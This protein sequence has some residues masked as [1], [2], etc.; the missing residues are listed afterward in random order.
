MKLI[1]RMK[2]HAIGSVMIVILVYL[3]GAFMGADINFVNWDPFGRFILVVLL[4]CCM[5]VGNLGIHELIDN[6]EE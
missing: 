6:Y 5:I 2:V 4:I 1:D 3:I